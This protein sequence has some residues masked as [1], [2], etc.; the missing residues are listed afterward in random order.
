MRAMDELTEVDDPAWP[1]LRHLLTGGQVPCRVLRPDPD[2]ARR[3]LMQLQVTARS[4]LGA[5]VLN[6]GGLLVDG[7]WLRVYGGGGDPGDPAGSPSLGQVNG[8]PAQADPA[9][10]PAA[11]LVVAHDVLGGVFALNG[12]DPASVGRPGGPGEMTYLAP[13]TL[14]WEALEGGHSAWLS[15]VFDGGAARFYQGL[16]WPGWQEEAA[17]LT[18]GQGIAVFPPLWSREAQA[19]LAATSRRAVPMRELL[20]VAADSA[21]Q[22]DGADLGFLGFC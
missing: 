7:G 16:R 21:R 5:L 18:A 2:E 20:G 11:G 19:D 8:F 13:D 6:T 3:C 10:R 17:V 22:L 9:W 4:T 12:G 1:E 14:A 15:W